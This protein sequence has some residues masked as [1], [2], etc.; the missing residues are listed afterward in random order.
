MDI[1]VKFPMNDSRL[2]QNRR[3][4]KCKLLLHLILYT[5]M[6]K[7]L[8][9]DYDAQLSEII[10]KKKKSLSFILFREARGTSQDNNTWCFELW[11]FLNYPGLQKTMDY[12]FINCF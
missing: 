4:I 5:S 11:A 9:W 1:Y 8:I 6:I 12:N 10:I 7:I 2:T 3:D